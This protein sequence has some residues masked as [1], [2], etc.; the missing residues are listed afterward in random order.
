VP[1][2][3]YCLSTRVATLSAIGYASSHTCQTASACL[4]CPL[5]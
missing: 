3:R 2:W 1:G 5:E 4:I